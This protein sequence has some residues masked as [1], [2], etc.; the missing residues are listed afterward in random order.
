MTMSTKV[1]EIK[2]GFKEWH[3]SFKWR[4]SRAPILIVTVASAPHLADA[5]NGIVRWYI[6][7][8]E[9]SEKLA[10]HL[11]C[12][13]YKRAAAFGVTDHD[14]THNSTYGIGGITKFREEFEQFNGTVPDEMC[15]Y[16][17]AKTASAQVKRFF[18]SY[19]KDEK[20]GIFVV[21]YGE[22]VKNTITELISGGYEGC[23]VCTSTL[24]D[25]QWQPPKHLMD[26]ANIFTVLPRLKNHGDHFSVKDHYVVF[27]FARKTLLRV[28]KLTAK[29]TNA[30]IFLESW[31]N[32]LEEGPEELNQEYLKCGDILV[33]LRTVNAQALK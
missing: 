23:I 17:T 30:K 2:D 1:E 5:K 29:T 28:L 24:T 22:M 15:F 3:A 14:G 4:K 12:L 8:E 6:R 19:R 18:S 7:S 27:F 25:K 10:D 16:V 13:G 33:R 32:G 11:N 20:L 21:G 9:E 31:M 26:K